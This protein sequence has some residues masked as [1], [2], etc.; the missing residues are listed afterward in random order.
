MTRNMIWIGFFAT[1]LIFITLGTAFLREPNRQADALLEQR[2]VAVT[3]GTDLFAENCAVCHGASGEGL[4]AYPALNSDALRTMDEV[5]LFR[6]IERGRY[7]TAMAAYGVEEGGIFTNAEIDNLMAVIQLADWQAVAVRVADLGLTP[8]EIEIVE[9][10]AETILAVAELPNSEPM[11]AGL[12]LYAENCA[13]CHGGSAEGSALAPALN[14]E[15][16]RNRMTDADLTRTIEQGVPTTLMASWDA[17]LTD[18]DV[19]DLVSL[20]RRWEEIESAGIEMPTITAPTID[21]SAEAIA[22]GQWLFGLLCAQCHG[23]SGYGSPMAP[24]LNNQIFLG[25]TPDAA[26]QQIIALGVSGTSMPAWGGRLTEADIASLT[27]YLRS[28]EPTAPAIVN[29]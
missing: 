4:A 1:L 18:E 8:P 25:E 12:T 14:S 26:I 19:A 24:A 10:P 13:A 22:E 28:W 23:T 29:P 27:A 9:M 3:E 15:E 7:N 6:T 11:V 21:M 2:I 5:D 16:L 20:I 17:A